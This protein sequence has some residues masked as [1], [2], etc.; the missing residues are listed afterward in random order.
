[1]SLVAAVLLN[2]T[3]E[4][5]CGLCVSTAEI[6]SYFW[7]SLSA[8]CSA[9]L[10]LPGCSGQVWIAAIVSQTTSSP[11]PNQ[12]FIT[13]YLIIIIAISQLLLRCDW[14]RRVLYNSRRTSSKWQMTVAQRILCCGCTA[15]YTACRWSPFF[16]S[17]P[18]EVFYSW[19]CYLYF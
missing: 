18:L 12:W 5:F 10:L 14:H 16:C 17:P 11:V 13:L 9:T 4:M 3:V 15:W 2:E 7:H 1:M 8:A 19:R 6:S